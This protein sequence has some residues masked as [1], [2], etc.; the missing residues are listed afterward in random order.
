[1]VRMNVKDFIITSSEKDLQQYAAYLQ[2]VKGFLAEAQKEIN[3]PERAKKSTLSTNSMRPTTGLFR[4]LSPFRRNVT[5]YWGRPSR[6]MGPCPK[7]N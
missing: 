7:K 1:M 6:N 2:K 5:P 4:R 3:D